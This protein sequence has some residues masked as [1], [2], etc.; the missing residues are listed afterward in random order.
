MHE[1]ALG[2]F[3]AD[4]DNSDWQADDLVL[5]FFSQ[6]PVGG[7]VR[8][9]HAHLA[10]ENIFNNLPLFQ[11][12]DWIRIAE[13]DDSLVAEEPLD[14]LSFSDTQEYLRSDIV[15]AATTA[16]TSNTG[17]GDSAAT[18]QAAQALLATLL[19][20]SEQQPRGYTRTGD[21]LTQCDDCAEMF[22]VS[23]IKEH[24]TKC[25]S[26]RGA[27]IEAESPGGDNISSIGTAVVVILGL[28]SVVSTSLTKVHRFRE[29]MTLGI[30]IRRKYTH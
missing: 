1:V 20:R 11:L 16:N 8:Q 13:W 26:R 6:A 18:G 21:G 5:A 27:W 15:L 19:G 17:G 4:E 9:N 23:Q 3:F 28:P 29:V 14:I 12:I 25:R 22:V 24:E 30:T 7:L 10:Q 2:A